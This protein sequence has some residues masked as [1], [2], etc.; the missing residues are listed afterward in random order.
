MRK[1]LRYIFTAWLLLCGLQASAQRFFNLTAEEVSIDS[2][3]PRFACSIPLG[4]HFADSIYRVSIDYPEFIPMSERDKREYR[5][6][7]SIDK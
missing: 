6:I 2:V 7:K 4:A 3:L 5:R 1:S